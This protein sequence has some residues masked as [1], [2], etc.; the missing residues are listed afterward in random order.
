MYADGAYYEQ[1]MYG[2]E[3]T[4]RVVEAPPGVIITTLPSG[5][6]RPTVSGVAVS[7][8]GNTLLTS[9]S[10]TGTRSLCSDP[11]SRYCGSAGAASDPSGSLNGCHGDALITHLEDL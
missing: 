2:G 10:A 11:P 5:V 4:Y 7:Q 8:C 6:H 9:V 3:V 1:V